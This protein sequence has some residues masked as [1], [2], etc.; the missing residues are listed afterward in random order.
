MRKI[1]PNRNN[2]IAPNKTIN[3][4][5]KKRNRYYKLIFN[6]FPIIFSILSLFISWNT[7]KLSE[8]V[9]FSNI[10]P[11]VSIKINNIS[12]DQC[13]LDIINLGPVLISEISVTRYF[14]IYF[15]YPNFMSSEVSDDYWKI[16]KNLFINDSLIYKID[17]NEFKWL[18]EDAE[19]ISK[20]RGIKDS[21]I[22]ILVIY[23]IKYMNEI[24]KRLFNS[25]KYLRIYRRNEN[26]NSFIG[27]E[28]HFMVE[29]NI[30]QTLDS[31]F[32]NY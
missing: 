14:V 13:E 20:D 2:I 17:A 16:S 30:K 10:K 23:H 19:N 7:Y 15:N 8:R 4:Y 5:Y 27:F 26:I 18:I 31:L 32:L 11:L 28:E 9:Y 24:D 1:I 21:E 22:N 6:S 25:L 3:S 29:R 12:D